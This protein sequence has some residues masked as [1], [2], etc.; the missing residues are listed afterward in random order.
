[1]AGSF[2][3]LD[4]AARDCASLENTLVPYRWP[5]IG[6]LAG[7]ITAKLGGL[8][9]GIVWLMHRYP[10]LL[11]RALGGT[12]ARLGSVAARC[13]CCLVRALR[14]G[15]RPLRTQAVSLPHLQA[16]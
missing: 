5:V 12:W 4:L 11:L 13:A 14:A 1:M 16:H 15:E 6:F 3:D 9:I 2:I 10:W 8:S 7:A